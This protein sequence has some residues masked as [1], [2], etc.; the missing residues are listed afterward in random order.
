MGMT[1]IGIKQR[2]QGTTMGRAEGARRMLLIHACLVSR[3]VK[4]A[5][6]EGGEWKRGGGARSFAVC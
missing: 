5:A 1:N 4:L 6:P 2:L 3:A